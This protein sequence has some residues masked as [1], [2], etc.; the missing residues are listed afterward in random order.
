MPVLS[1][2]SGTS[3]PSRLGCIAFAVIAI[4]T[5]LAWLFFSADSDDDNWLFFD[6]WRTR[7][8][9]VA[10]AGLWLAA[11]GL[12]IALSRRT[13]FK[14]ILATLIA[15]AT[16]TILEVAGFLGLVN[17]THLFHSDQHLGLAPVP[18][19]DVHGHTYQDTAYSWGYPT[20]PMPFH[21]RS[22]HQGYRNP[23]DRREADI[24]M[25][26]DSILVAALLP[27]NRTVTALLEHELNR[28]TM[29]LALI[30]AGP[31]QQR[32]MLLDAEIP[33]EDRLVLHFIFEGNDLLDSCTYRQ[34][35]DSTT[36]NTLGLF[37]GSLTNRLAVWA[38]R[39]TDPTPPRR[40]RSYGLIGDQ[41][42]LFTWTNRSFIG[43]MS[44][45]PHIQQ[46]IADLHA[47]VID[48]G[49]RYAIAYI[50]AKIRVLGSFCEFPDDSSITD[51]S[52]HLNPMRELFLTWCQEQNIDAIDL[53]E[54]LVASARSGAVP[55]FWGDTHPNSIG[56]EVM[57]QVLAEWCIASSAPPLDR[58]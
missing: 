10:A 49:G 33:L 52:R 58:K 47:R 55:W 35:S 4:I 17:Y 23:E 43:R 27:F 6:H 44:E 7:H 37:Q 18:H 12:F 21:Y 51:Y 30:G 25:L 5:T 13:L 19:L 1:A 53:T 42:Y 26:G 20:A 38:Q 57:A 3:P 9:L 45:L 54:P 41:T 56:H 40:Y 15:S 11:A 34:A 22:D 16:L 50:P 28:T 36:H 39:V 24:Y 8:I 46:A 32:Q 48:A 29:N 31:Q 2:S 14:F